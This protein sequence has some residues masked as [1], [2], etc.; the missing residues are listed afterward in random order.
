MVERPA[1]DSLER[2]RTLTRWVIQTREAG[3]TQLPEVRAQLPRY[4]DG[5]KQIFS[6][7]SRYS[8][9][10]TSPPQI[11]VSPPQSCRRVINPIVPHRGHDITATNGFWA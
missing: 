7:S 11:I 2:K 1:A 8:A 4:C 6:P 9:E 10:H 3:V 5:R